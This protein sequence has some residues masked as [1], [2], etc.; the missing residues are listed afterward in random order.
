MYNA[1][2]TGLDGPL[3]PKV[4]EVRVLVRGKPLKEGVAVAQ[5]KGETLKL[6]D[7][8][9]PFGFFVA[10]IPGCVPPREVRVEFLDEAGARIGNARAEDAVVS[11][12]GKT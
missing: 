7:A 8:E 5:V 9:E 1:G 3:T 10:F 12:P 4:A 11:C 6:I 2:M